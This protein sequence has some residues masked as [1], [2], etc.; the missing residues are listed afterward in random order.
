MKAPLLSA[1]LLLSGCATAD[2]AQVA[3]S[4]TTMVA[5]EAG[6]SEGNPVFH[7]AGW[8]VIVATKIGATQLIKLTPE[9]VCNSGLLALTVTGIGAAAW[10]IGAMMGCG[11]AALPFAVV[12]IWNE[13]DAWRNDAV[14]DCANAKSW[15]ERI[16]SGVSNA[17]SET[18][19]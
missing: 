9:P 11:L 10:N 3:D 6:F 14:R 8:P 4:F 12:I 18:R 7:G 5:L 17:S 13:W 2:H 15:L 16:Y 19:K 1:I